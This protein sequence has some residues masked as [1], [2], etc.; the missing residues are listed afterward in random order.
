[1]FYTDCTTQSVATGAANVPT[2][3][4]SHNVA[5]GS[6][7][8]GNVLTLHVEATL[9]GS[10][11]IDGNIMVKLGGQYVTTIDMTNTMIADLRIR[12][13]GMN[14]G[15]VVMEQEWQGGSALVGPVPLTGLAWG[16]AQALTLTG[17]ANQDGGLIL[18][19]AGVQR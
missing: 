18:Q 12:R 9:Y 1:M 13:T 15:E 10:P 3:L 6:V 8:L 4:W 7:A 5:G 2:Q 17:S 16:A 19:S 11:E 14:T